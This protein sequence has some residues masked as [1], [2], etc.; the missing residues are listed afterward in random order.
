MDYKRLQ[1]DLRRL[2]NDVRRLERLVQGMQRQIATNRTQKNIS[3]G[4]ISI[5][6]DRYSRLDAIADAI[7]ARLEALE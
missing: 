1:N 4:V 3:S 5:L 2:Q 7:E 6:G